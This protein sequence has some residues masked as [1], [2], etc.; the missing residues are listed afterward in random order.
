MA[1]ENIIE[2]VN[3]YLLD[4]EAFANEFLPLRDTLSPIQRDFQTALAD[5]KNKADNAE[6]LADRVFYINRYTDLVRKV[7]SVFDTRS[8]RLQ[9]TL[10]MLMKQP[11]LPTKNDIEDT[12]TAEEDIENTALTPEQANKI[13]EILRET[14]K[15]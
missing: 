2:K 12:N 4:S 7:E 1:K 14:E 11:E 10:T 13:L 15:N 9:Q 8:K 3:N 6:D 5:L